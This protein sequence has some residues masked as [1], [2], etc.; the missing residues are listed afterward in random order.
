L[1]KWFEEN[2]DNKNSLRCGRYIGIS[3]YYLKNTAQASQWLQRG[4]SDDGADAESLSMLGEIYLK[5]KE[6]DEI[7]LKLCEKSVEIDPNNVM[8][9]LRYARALSACGHQEQA[10]EILKQCVRK[11]NVKAESLL[12]M[13]EIYVKQHEISKCRQCLK[14]VLALQNISTAVQSKAKRLYKKLQ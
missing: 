1:G 11:N 3:S 5:G 7:A 4:L 14:K 6:G 12:E 9:L 13:A 2:K 8:L 10:L